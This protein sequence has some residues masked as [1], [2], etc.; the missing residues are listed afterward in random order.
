MLI[1]MLR[2]LGEEPE[3]VE[4]FLELVVDEDLALLDVN[5]HVLVVAVVVKHLLN[6]PVGSQIDH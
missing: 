4:L 5:L 6:Q 3:D 2:L 1:V